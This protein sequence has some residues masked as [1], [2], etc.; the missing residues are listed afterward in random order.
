MSLSLKL[1]IDRYVG[2]FCIFWLNFAARTLGFLMSR[3]HDLKVRGDILVIKML[4]GG[5]LVMAYPALLGIRR[6][7]P[8]AKMRLFTTEAVKHFA[9]T[10]GVFDSILVLDDSSLPKLLKSGFQGLVSTFLSD[11]V[12]DLEIYSYLS[13]V[14]SLLTCARNRLGFFFDETGFRERLHTHRVFFQ[15][16][17]P[18]YQHYDCIAHMV[19]AEPIASSGCASHLRA[20]LQITDATL[21]NSRRVVVGCGCSGLSKERKLMPEQWAQHVF[22]KSA[23]QTRD[24]L[25]LGSKADREEADKVIQAVKLTHAW[26]GQLVNAC[27]DMDLATSLR[28]LAEGE[29]YW[30]IESSLLQYA[31]LF[32]IKC[33]AFLGPTHP[34]RLRPQEGL[35]EEIYYRKTL[36][37]P[38]IHLVSIPPCHGDNLCMKWLFDKPVEKEVRGQWLP[39]V[40]DFKKTESV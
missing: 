12:I 33:K 17:T 28:A 39:V 14:F 38:C 3:E 34:M 21:R 10:L 16:A 5:S 27:G 2:I 8:D 4:G 35:E 19:G 1:F 31:R 18:L 23:D 26:Q 30:G 7:Y 6:A 15:A 22:A 32:G 36:C 9:E 40:T 37:S 11:T 29:E 20:A 24:V 13:T 25:F